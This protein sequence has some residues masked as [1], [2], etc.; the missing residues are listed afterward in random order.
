MAEAAQ[1]DLQGFH[2]EVDTFGVLFNTRSWDF[3]ASQSFGG[4]REWSFILKLN[5]LRGFHPVLLFSD[6]AKELTGIFSKL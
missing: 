3:C 4:K 6:L 2:W 1:T 5:L